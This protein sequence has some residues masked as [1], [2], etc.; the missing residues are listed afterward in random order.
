MDETYIKVK[1]RWTYRVVTER[2]MQETKQKKQDFA[3]FTI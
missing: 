2:R 1:G 3:V